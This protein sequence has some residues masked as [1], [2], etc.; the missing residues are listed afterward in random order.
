[1]CWLSVKSTR[2]LR[3]L[4][5]SISPNYTQFKKNIFLAL[6]IKEDNH[7]FLHY[8]PTTA[9]LSIQLAQIP[10]MPLQNLSTYSQSNFCF[11]CKSGNIAFC[12]LSQIIDIE[13]GQ[14][15]L[16]VVSHKSQLANLRKV[17]LFPRFTCCLI[18]NFQSTSVYYPQ[19]CVL[20]PCWPGKQS[21]QLHWHF[22]C[23]S[24]TSCVW[25]GQC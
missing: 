4:W 9:C 18:A 20:Q 15:P 11:I 24:G 5:T 21:A 19:L 25:I 3:S 7:I 23:R 13:Q 6:G 22:P 10:L 2:T 8:I 16:P 14:A 1:M 12:P 17:R